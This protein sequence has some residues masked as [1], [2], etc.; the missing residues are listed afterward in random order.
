METKLAAKLYTDGKIEIVPLGG[1]QFL[2]DSVGGY[3]QA[4]DLSENLTIWMNEE[5]KMNSLPFNQAATSIYIKFL[6]S[7]D[8]IVG[9]VVFTGGAD[10]DGEVL[11]LDEQTIA[12]LKAYAALSTVQ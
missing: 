5:G 12:V 3:V 11:G 6:G 8:F 1:L 2:Q 4:M 9:T 10:E 7:G